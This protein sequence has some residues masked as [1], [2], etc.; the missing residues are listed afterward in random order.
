VD[1]KVARAGIVYLT[2]NLLSAAVP[3]LLMPLLTRVLAP[4]EYGA[5][6]NYFMLVAWCTPIAGLSI[7]GALGV[8]WFRKEPQEF[9]LYA[10]SALV[11]AIGSSLVVALLVAAG[12]AALPGLE[13]GFGPGVASLA[14][15]AAGANIILQCRLVLWQNQQQPVANITLQ[16]AASVLNMTLS[17]VG[18][19]VLG[20][21]ASGRIFGSAAASVIVAIA[22]ILYLNAGGLISIRPRVADL[23]ELAMFGGP[24][25]PHG[26]AG[27][28][29][30]NGDRFIVS[31]LLGPASVGTYGAAAQVGSL[32]NV[33]GDAFVKTFNPWLF[34]RLRRATAD[35]RLEVVGAMYMA[36]P[37]FLV[38][39]ALAWLGL[40]LLGTLLL[41]PQFR[42]ALSLL[43]WFMFGGACSGVY[44]A[45]SGLFFYGERTGALSAISFPV[46]LV[47]L[48]ITAGLVSWH[49]AAGAAMGYALVQLLLAIV[50]W[51]YARRAFG[52]PFERPGAA[53]RAWGIGLSRK[54]GTR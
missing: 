42:S 52:L 10:G 37:G 54:E 44:L 23:R 46:A 35:D 32:M 20:W 31:T 6:I 17:I 33:A 4:A 51:Q 36:V 12:V 8:A 30:A 19:L 49:G 27:A 1:T 41:G 7:H 3:F 13:L 14:A 28:L 22:A 9:P 29:L 38:L 50:S 16:I 18:V 43:P 5:I 24:L 26:F 39:A 40:H 25:A 53:L 48:G 45:I 47:G 34:A 21:A 11:L 15:I 2:G